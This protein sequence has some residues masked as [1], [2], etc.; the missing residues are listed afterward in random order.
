MRYVE[1][2]IEEA[3]KVCNKQTK[4]LVSVQS[5]EDDNVCL[6]FEQKKKED[7]DKIFE[8]VQTIASCV[9]E[10]AKQLR[11]FTAKQNIYDIKPIGIQ[12]I[13]LLK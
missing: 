8:D 11:C 4:V 13:V 3:M 12:K 6:A 2:S 1:M 5:L 7:Y 9:D 10:F